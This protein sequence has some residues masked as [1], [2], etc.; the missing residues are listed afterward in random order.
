[1]ART[2]FSVKI[3]E[4]SK[5]LTPKE[6]VMMKDFSNAVKLDTVC[7]NESIVIYPA[8]HVV[9]DVHNSKSENPDYVNYLI[10]DKA[11]TKYVTGS[12]SF[13]NAYSDIMSEMY[14]VD[15]D[16]WGLEIFKLDSKNY[17]GKKFL[18]CSII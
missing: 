10:V 12:P 4:A 3:R 11:G 14:E 5:E 6:K 8:Y 18:T 2:E 1:M 16:D 15:D 17:T 7:E 9:L 13:W